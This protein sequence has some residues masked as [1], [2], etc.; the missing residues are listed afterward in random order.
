MCLIYLYTYTVL[1]YHIYSVLYRRCFSVLSVKNM[2][3]VK[4][5]VFAFCDQSE[6]I[7]AIVKSVVVYVVNFHPTGRLGY[8][9]VHS[10]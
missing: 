9:S 4:V 10:D 5:P 8:E 2:P 1:I 7:K 3:A 6:I